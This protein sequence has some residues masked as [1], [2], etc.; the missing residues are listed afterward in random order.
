MIFLTSFASNFLV[1]SWGYDLVT[2]YKH[3]EI[4]PGKE[5]SLTELRKEGYVLDDKQWLSVSILEPYERPS[6]SFLS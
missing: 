2:G 4:P 1:A 5:M 6:T 3:K